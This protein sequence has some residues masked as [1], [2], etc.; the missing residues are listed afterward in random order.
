M[1]FK[2]LRLAGAFLIELE[3]HFDE[4][5]FF[6]RTY[7]EAEFAAHGLPRTFPQCNLSRSHR[8]GTLRGMHFEEQP[9]LESKLVSC[10][11]GKLYDVIVD[12][13]PDSPTLLQWV[14]VELSAASA[15]RLFVP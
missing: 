9:T 4:R 7:C 3:P 6:A 14:G 1:K 11:S 13:R 5:G 2:E 10:S 8:L 12:L 15:V